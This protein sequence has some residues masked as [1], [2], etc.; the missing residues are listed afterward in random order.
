MNALTL[1]YALSGA[2]GL[3]G[4]LTLLALSI[5]VH[6]GHLHPA[7]SL[8]WVGSDWVIALAALFTVLDFIGDKIPGVDHALHAVHTVLAPVIGAVAAVSAQ[9][10]DS[11]SPEVLTALLGGANALLVHATRA[12]TRVATTGA[13]L[14]VANPFVSLAGDFATSA[15]IVIAFLAPVVAA[16]LL[17]LFTLQIIRWIRR[18]AARASNA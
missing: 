17:V 11:T 7:A 14:G 13:T 1:S 9:G 3:R 2:A 15:L 12:G 16:V 8:A 18:L 5:A 10:G 4:P 6:T